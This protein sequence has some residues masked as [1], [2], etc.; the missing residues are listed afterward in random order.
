M[1]SLE[2]QDIT[3]SH[4]RLIIIQQYLDRQQIH[5][6]ICDKGVQ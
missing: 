1:M 3:Q 5:L 4:G 2:N 6:K